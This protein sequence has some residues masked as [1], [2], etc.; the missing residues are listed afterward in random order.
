MPREWHDRHA[1]NK[2]DDDQKR[3]FYRSIVADKKP[4]FMRYIYPAL[5]KQYNTYIKN[6]DRNALRE[7]QMT[8]NE[9]KAL[10]SSDL[11][12]RQAEFLKYFDIRMPVGVGDCVMNKICRRFEEEFD[13]HVGRHNA[14]SD[15]DY[16]IMKSGVEYG[17]SQFYSIK[18]LYDDYNRRVRNYMVFADYERVDSLD[19]MSELINMDEEFRKACDKV[20]SNEE[21]L[22]DIIL[23]L[24]YRRST[25]K[26][27]AWGMCG[28]AI[29]NNL[30]SKNN[31]QISFPEADDDGDVVYFG[32]NF[33][34]KTVE[35]GVLNG[36]S[37]ERK[38]MGSETDRGTQPWEETV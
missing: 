34:V 35:M 29:I 12:E 15:F 7:F 20:C 3:S 38:R 10:P 22:C 2:I 32:M 30:L 17:E 14:R 28:E 23:D 25:T 37:I 26:K 8:V 18:K 11:T 4:Y 13:G 21:T 16:R 36:N 33:S 19:A 27:F 1:A 24:C 6:T 31:Y 9:M 5:M